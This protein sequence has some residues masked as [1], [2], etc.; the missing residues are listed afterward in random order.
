MATVHYRFALPVVRVLG[1]LLFALV[2]VGC[3]GSDPA[4]GYLHGTWEQSGHT[5]N[6]R[7]WDYGN[8]VE[9][10][11]DDG[12]RVSGDWDRLVLTSDVETIPWRRVMPTVYANGDVRAR[13]I[14]HR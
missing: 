10:W 6:I 7:L 5:C 1:L 14:V 3:G 12:R 9:G 4:R 13:L 11:T 2:F 8:R